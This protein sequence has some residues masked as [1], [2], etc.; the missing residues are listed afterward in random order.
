MTTLAAFMFRQDQTVFGA[1][2]CFLLEI[3]PGETHSIA[4]GACETVRLDRIGTFQ[5]RASIDGYQ[6]EWTNVRVSKDD[7]VQLLILPPGT[8]GG[9]AF[10]LVFDSGNY[11]TIKEVGR[12]KI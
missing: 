4:G 8:R 7:V 11:L 12:S 1:D 3:D 5:L 10:G 2:S 9:R 6:S